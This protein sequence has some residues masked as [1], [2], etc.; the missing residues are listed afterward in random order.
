[1]KGRQKVVLGFRENPTCHHKKNSRKQKSSP[2]PA[3][4]NNLVSCKQGSNYQS[5]LRMVAS[6][7]LLKLT[8]NIVPVSQLGPI[9]FRDPLI[10][11]LG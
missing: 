4:A 9:F 8:K 6:G 7:V 5:D 11:S 1:M 3:C 10:F 2:F